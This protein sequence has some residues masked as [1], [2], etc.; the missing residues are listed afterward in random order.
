MCFGIIIDM[1]LDLVK[2]YDFIDQYRLICFV[3]R[4]V[5]LFSVFSSYINSNNFVYMI[6]PL[7]HYIMYLN[8]R[9][10]QQ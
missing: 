4:D 8:I 2:S 9:M 1:Y 6:S 7:K 3:G 5:L 10:I